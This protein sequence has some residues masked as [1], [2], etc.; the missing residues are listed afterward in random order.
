MAAT[1][2]GIGENMNSELTAEE[3]RVLMAYNAAEH[4]AQQY[5]LELLL[6][7]PAEQKP[8][9]E[10]HGNLVLVSWING[11]QDQQRGGTA[12]HE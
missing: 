11:R 10:Q 3:K 9:I 8:H 2:A 6:K 4:A 1:G 12:G 5:A 7:H